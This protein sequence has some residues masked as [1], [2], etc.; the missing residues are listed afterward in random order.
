MYSQNL[1]V[2]LTPKFQIGDHV[3]ITKKEK[4]FDKG[5][6]QWQT[7][8][9]FKISKIQLTIP[10]TYKMTDYIGEEFK[11]RFMNKNFKRLHRAHSWIDT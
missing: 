11:H 2:R 4:T 5:Y 1:V 7:E 8:E 10:V 9:V 3:R 6:T